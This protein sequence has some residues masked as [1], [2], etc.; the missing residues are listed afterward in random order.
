M[1]RKNKLVCSEIACVYNWKSGLQLWILCEYVSY[2]LPLANRMDLYYLPLLTIFPNTFE[3]PC[4]CIYVIQKLFLIYEKKIN[5]KNFIIL[6]LILKTFL[7]L[8][9]SNNTLLSFVL[10]N[11][12]SFLFVNLFFLCVIDSSYR[13]QYRCNGF[14]KT[15]SGFT[16]YNLE[17]KY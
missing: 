7:V 9:K 14:R 13:S 8:I 17:W 5:T 3:A 15:F 11:F 16:K 6:C 10:L 2:D 12:P 4:A 1:L